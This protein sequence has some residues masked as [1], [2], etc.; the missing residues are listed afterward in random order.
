VVSAS[1]AAVLENI[2]GAAYKFT[3]HTYD[4]LYGARSFNS[5]EDYAKEAGRSRLL[6]GIH[7]S[8]SITVGLTQ[9]KQIGELVNKLQV[10]K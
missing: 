10:Q 9:G 7:Y 6:G 2:F 5:F 3:D 4:K 8:P 1:S